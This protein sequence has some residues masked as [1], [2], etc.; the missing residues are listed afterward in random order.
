MRRTFLLFSLILSFGVG[1]LF[2]QST[3]NLVPNPSFED[4]IQLSNGQPGLDTW[5]TNIGTPDYFSDLYT[6]PFENRKSKNNFRGGELA[7]DGEAI[8]GFVVLD[9]RMGNSREYMQTQ[10]LDSLRKGEPYEVKFF[11][12]L[13]DSFHF[14]VDQKDI[15][16]YFTDSLEPNNFDHQVREFRPFYNSDSTWNA[17]SKDGWEEFNYTYTAKGGENTLVIGCFKK[18]HELTIDS[19][20]DGGDFPLAYRGSYYFIDNISVRW[21][22]TT[23]GLAEN[24]LAQQIHLYPN[25]VR[26]NLCLKYNGQENL[27]FSLFDLSGKSYNISSDF[28]NHQHSFQMGHLPI[29]VYLLQVSDGIRRSTFKVIRQ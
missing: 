9:L 16:I 25:P 21:V 22:D 29:G 8:F 28:S 18:N 4:T 1:A 19:V 3:Q 23:I 17:S 15:G 11:I 7:K 26:E 2:S 24:T 6:I 10:L 14:A 12:S 5:Q 13:A 27:Q 20:G